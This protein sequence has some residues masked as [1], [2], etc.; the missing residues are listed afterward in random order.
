M[1]KIKKINEKLRKLNDLRNSPFEEDD[2][3]YDKEGN[4]WEVGKDTNYNT[5]YSRVDIGDRKE[6]DYET[7]KQLFSLDY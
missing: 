2:L 6:F 3:V 4:E 1:E 7:A 5:I